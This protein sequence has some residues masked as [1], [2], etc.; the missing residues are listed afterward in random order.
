MIGP[1][2]DVPAP[3]YGTGAKEMAWIKDT[4]ET[5]NPGVCACERECV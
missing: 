2:M 4:F 5:F 3:D 1:G